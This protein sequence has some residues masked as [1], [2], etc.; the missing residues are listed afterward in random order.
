MGIQSVGYA[1]PQVKA[2]L[3]PFKFAHAFGAHVV[4]FTTSLAKKDDALR[5]GASSALHWPA[6]SSAG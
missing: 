3:V 5:M 4:L 6:R 1:A 2:P